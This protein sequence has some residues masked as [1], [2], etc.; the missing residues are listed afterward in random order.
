MLNLAQLEKTLRE[1]ERRADQLIK[2]CEQ[3]SDERERE[4][5]KQV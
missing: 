3:E 2:E 5:Q 4:H 1:N